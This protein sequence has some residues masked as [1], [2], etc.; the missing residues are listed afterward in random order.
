[1]NQLTKFRNSATSI[2]AKVKAAASAAVIAALATPFGAAA[3]N[4]GTEVKTEIESGK[5]ELWM[6]G[7][8]ILILCVVTAL[9]N[10]GKSVTN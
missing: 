6:I 4:F 10:R 8:A 2:S 5:A 9:V 3:Q 1:M 7:G